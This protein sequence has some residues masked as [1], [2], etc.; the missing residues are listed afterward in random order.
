MEYLHREML[1]PLVERIE[2]EA[3]EE[4]YRATA[5]AV[6]DALGMSTERIGSCTLL[7]AA[8]VPAVMFNRAFPFGMSDAVDG[9]TAAKLVE[10]FRSAGITTFAVQP[11]PEGLPEPVAAALRAHGMELRDNWVKMARDAATPQPVQCDL[12]IE[13]IHH[14][15]SLE[16]GLTVCAAYG[17]PEALAPLPAGVVGCPGWRHYMAFDGATPVATGALYVRD[18]IGW[19]G[20]GGTLPTHRRRGA[21]NALMARRITDAIESGCRWV[22]TETGE[23][24]TT[25]PNP[26]YRNMV[27]MGFEL[28]HARPNFIAMPQAQPA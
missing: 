8:R 6:R 25:R 1:A 19:L 9:S 2:Q 27:R 20:I 14:Q 23:E 10:R 5:P 15:R 16:F 26:S 21:Q 18:G 11:G 22:T 3:W 13:Q 12:R 4:I 17:M 28:V 24:T 7:L